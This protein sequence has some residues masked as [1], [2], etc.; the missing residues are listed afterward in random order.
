MTLLASPTRL[1]RN[2][3]LAV[4]KPF[5]NCRMAFP[6]TDTEERKQMVPEKGVEPSR[7]YFQ[8]TESVCGKLAARRIHEYLGGIVRGSVE[9]ATTVR[10]CASSD[11]DFRW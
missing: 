3:T 7:P 11:K 4:D 8:P 6:I 10:H 5:L 1:F 9:A 2:T